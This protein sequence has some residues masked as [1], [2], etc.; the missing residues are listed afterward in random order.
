[1]NVLAINEPRAKIFSKNEST[2]NKDM[3]ARYP[4]R[5]ENINHKT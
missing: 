5:K 4:Q 2:S 1:M 3:T